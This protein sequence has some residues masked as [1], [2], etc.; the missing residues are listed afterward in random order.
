MRRIKT[1]K[2]EITFDGEYL[3]RIQL[4]ENAD[5]DGPDILAINKAKF[6]LIGE[7][8]HVVL[9]VPSIFSNMTA[10]ARKVSATS[11]VNRNSLAKAIIVLSPHQRIIV[12]FFIKFNRPPAP[13]SVFTNDK[14]AL[15]WLEKMKKSAGVMH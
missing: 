2:A 10:D 9:F 13:T 14:D 5:L 15:V 7:R 6:E 4:F 12:N 8:K 11:E 1:D 3:V